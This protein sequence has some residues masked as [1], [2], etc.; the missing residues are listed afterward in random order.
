MSRTYDAF[1]KLDE[2]KTPDQFD[3]EIFCRFTD[4]VKGPRRRSDWPVW[5]FWTFYIGVWSYVCW[6]AGKYFELF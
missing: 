3:S 1:K 6:V 5:T 2:R 4:S